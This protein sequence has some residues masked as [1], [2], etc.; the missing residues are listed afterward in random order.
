M[1][2][3]VKFQERGEYMFEKLLI[4][5][6]MSPRSDAIIDCVGNLKNFGAKE[7]MLLQCMNTQQTSSM[8]F[9]YSTSIIDHILEEKKEKLEALG[10]KV[11]TMIETGFP[12]KIVNKVAVKKDCSVVVVGEVEHSQAGEIMFDRLTYDVIHS[13]EKPV[14]II[15]LI[16]NS[17]TKKHEMKA[18]R[19]ELNKH[20]LFPTDFSE[21]AGHAFEYLKKI[22]SDGVEKVTLMHVQEDSKIKPPL[23]DEIEELNKI[24]R[25]RL[26]KMKNDLIDNNN[27]DIDIA[28]KYG[29]P[30][31]EILNL[32]DEKDISLVL[33]GSQGRGFIKEL[34]I[35]SVSHSIAR[36]SNASVLLVPFN[37]SQ[38]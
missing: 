29:K 24:D 31:E 20:V 7:C 30:T 33:M 5:S 35:G 15:R 12:K 11:D 34:F 8:A 22:V 6:D 4:V 16:R 27:L 37:E 10:F 23:D 26:E 17:K 32:I 1:K 3:D 25:D 13:S 38:K 14:L 9:S 18:V 21:N 36:H 19:C 28:I 2:K